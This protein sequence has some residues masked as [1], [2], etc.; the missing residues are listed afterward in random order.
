MINKLKLLL[1]II[2]PNIISEYPLIEATELTTSSGAE[3]PKETIVN[4]IIRSETLYFFANADEPST[5]Q[6]APNINAVKPAIIK[7]IKI[8]MYYRCVLMHVNLFS[9]STQ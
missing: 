7:T 9:K 2:F 8:T 6:F 5:N 3:V 1:P 4:P